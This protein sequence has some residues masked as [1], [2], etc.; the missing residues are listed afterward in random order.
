MATVLA[1]TL[2]NKGVFSSPEPLTFPMEKADEVKIP[3]LLASNMLM[4][5]DRGTMLGSM[6]TAS[7]MLV[8]AYPE[9]SGVTRLLIVMAF[10]TAEGH[11]HDTTHQRG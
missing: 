1:K 4:R 3:K 5:G 7:S 11:W 10:C 8:G 6:A 2:Y 9:G